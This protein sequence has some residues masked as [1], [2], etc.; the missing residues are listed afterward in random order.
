MEEVLL[1]GL[2]L[3][4]SA[5]NLPLFTA[6]HEQVQP[7]VSAGFALP[8]FAQNLPVFSAPHSHFHEPAA[9]FGRGFALPQS[10]QNL[11]VFVAPHS[12]FFHESADGAL[13]AVAPA[14][15]CCVSHIKEILRIHSACLLSHSHTEKSHCRTIRIVCSAL[16]SLCLRLN[17]SCSSICRICIPCSVLEFLNTLCICLGNCSGINSYLFNFKTS[18]FPS[19]Q[20]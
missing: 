17:K 3:P 8:Q 5:Q 20:D 7:S 19:A 10:A 11:P 1:P 18:T 6:P 15:A 9:G 16:H 13:F 12:H 14:A 2:G 4:H